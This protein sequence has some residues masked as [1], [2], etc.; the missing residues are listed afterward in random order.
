MQQSM[1][2]A[3]YRTMQTARLTV[4][5]RCSARHKPVQHRRSDRW[6]GSHVLGTPVRA[7]AHAAQRLA[8][9]LWGQRPTEYPLGRLSDSLSDDPS[10]S[11]SRSVTCSSS[12]DSDQE[13][14]PKGPYHL[15][16]IS[17][18]S[19][20][21]FEQRH[22]SANPRHASNKQHRVSTYDE[23]YG[24]DMI[25]MSHKSVFLQ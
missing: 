12:S 23:D 8:C 7:H 16:T 9:T 2:A 4:E 20:A 3:S 19:R 13:V 22:I 21:A 10:S 25:R 15:W 14:Q 11:L 17:E 18:A 6:S 24:E 5:S 1:Y